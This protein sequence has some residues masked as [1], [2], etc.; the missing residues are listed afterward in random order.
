MW[1]DSWLR[2]VP[3]YHSLFDEDTDYEWSEGPD[4][5]SCTQL[6]EHILQGVGLGCIDVLLPA[7]GQGAAVPASPHWAAGRLP[8]PERVFRAML[9]QATSASEEEQ[10]TRPNKRPAHTFAD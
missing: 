10:R 1:Y 4:D 3:I 7:L 6:V 2:G 5:L 8:W 9:A